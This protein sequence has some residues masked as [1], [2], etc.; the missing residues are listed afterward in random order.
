MR[1]FTLRRMFG[2][3][4]VGVAYVHGKRGGD[5]SYDSIADTLRYVWSTIS[6]RL[7]LDHREPRPAKPQPARPAS[8]TSSPTSTS[9]TSSRLPPN[10]LSGERNPRS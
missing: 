10:G 8:S 7:G 2:L 5:A 3:A 6:P 4:V 9:S 1:I